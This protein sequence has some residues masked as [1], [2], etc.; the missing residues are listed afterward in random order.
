VF[1][2]LK[3]FLGPLLLG[4]LLLL[5]EGCLAPSARLPVSQKTDS[6][7]SLI[8][9]QI[10]R[11]I[12]A[13]RTDSPR[14]REVHLLQRYYSLHSDRPAWVV[15]QGISAAA[16]Q[17]LG[18]LEAAN[19]EGLPPQRY[20]PER[21]R[22]LL[23]PPAG[24]KVAYRGWSPAEVARIDVALSR[25]FF[26][27]AGDNLRGQER[28]WKSRGD[29]HRH[30]R[31]VNP[32]QLLDLALELD[33]LPSALTEI[34]PPYP[35]YRQLRQMLRRYRGLA[36]LGG[37]PQINAGKTLHPG[38]SDPRVSALRRRLQLEGDLEANDDQGDI[39]T[40]EMQRGLRR[41]QQRHGLTPDATLGPQTLRALNVSVEQRIDQIIRNMERWR[42][43]SGRTEKT[44]I[45]IN[46]AAFSL[47]AVSAGKVQL[48][49]PVIIGRQQRS[50]PLF[51]SQLE[52]L[53]LSPYWYVPPTLLH[54][55]LP[56][57]VADSTYLRRNH[58][59]V[60]NSQ[61]E[62]LQV[63]SQFR[64][65]WQQGEVSAALRQ[66][67]GPW[68]P[69]GQIKFLLPNPWSIY[70]HDTPGKKL[71]TRTRRAY[72]SGCIRL[73]QPQDLARWLLSRHAASPRQVEDILNSRGSR[74]V[75]LEKPV[76]LKIGYWTAWVDP[77]GRMNFRDDIYGRDRR[78][79]REL[80][81]DPPVFASVSL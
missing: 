71:F 80:R 49:M 76:W 50:T 19:E 24:E 13:A 79:A 58:Y 38:E 67:P 75:R 39:F 32:V 27:Y 2:R 18:F 20:E 23:Q 65:K 60:L 7:L 31:D 77:S 78:L 45:R 12:I 70:L 34:T 9:R 26:R 43:E 47:E 35:G 72:S 17:L 4:V 52:A 16:W 69:M 30:P 21:L 44:E 57:I 56:R 51:V 64:R 66:Q 81:Q 33:A 61:G 15:R 74:L 22:K 42:W 62:V 73:S 53:V 48:Q 3:L 46:L 25:A 41:F 63:D 11:R 68:N 54:E 1:K 29:W 55:A 5:A 59:E 10:H 6:Q 28:S 14:S 8:S 37:W 40:L 36:I